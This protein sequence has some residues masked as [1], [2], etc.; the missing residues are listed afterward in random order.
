M[1]LPGPGD[2]LWCL[3]LER[4]FMF[5]WKNEIEIEGLSSNLNFCAW[6]ELRFHKAVVQVGEDKSHPSF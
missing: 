3:V 2:E 5:R 6:G 4:G 1:T